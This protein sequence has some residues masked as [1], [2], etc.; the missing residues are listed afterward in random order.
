[1]IKQFVPQ[2][3]CLNC[4]GCCRFRQANSVW[5]PCLL[6]QE[7][8]NL[9]DKKIGQVYISADRRLVPVA[10]PDKNGFI[11]PCLELESNKCKIYSLRPFECQLYP[12]LINLRDKKVLLT[13]DLNCP[14]IKENINNNEFKEY[15]EYLA[16]FLNSPAQLKILK[17]NPQI[18]QAYEDVKEVLE[19]NIDNETK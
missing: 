5:S 19:L 3:F 8:Q 18:L 13:V 10:N 17:E 7:I 15:S 16:E 14:Y 12:F 11:C 9:L 4:Q 6:D 2:E 1:M